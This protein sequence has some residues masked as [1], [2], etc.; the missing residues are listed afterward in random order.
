MTRIPHTDSDGGSGI[1]LRIDTKSVESSPLSSGCVTPTPG[2]L[3]KTFSSGNL[4]TLKEDV[5]L[6]QSMPLP[7]RPSPNKGKSQLAQAID[8]TFAAG[9]EQSTSSSPILSLSEQDT[10]PTN[11]IPTTPSLASPVKSSSNLNPKSSPTKSPSLFERSRIDNGGLN[12]SRSVL[13]KS[14]TSPKK[15]ITNAAAQKP[16]K[17]VRFE[18]YTCF[19]DMLRQQDITGVKRLLESCVIGASSGDDPTVANT[20]IQQQSWFKFSRP[21]QACKMSLFKP[22]LLN[23]NYQNH[24]GVSPLHICAESGNMELLDFIL[25][26]APRSKVTV[27]S[28]IPGA[29]LE[30][31]EEYDVAT[32]NGIYL[33][34][35]DIEGWTPLHSASAEGHIDVV[36]RLVSL[37]ANLHAYNYDGENVYDVAEEE[38]MKAAI[39]GND[40]TSMKYFIY[41]TNCSRTIKT[42]RT[43]K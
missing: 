6:V 8:S 23:L 24:M 7:P 22:K 41:F 21:A 30:A 40:H 14:S 31:S 1:G 25:E 42:P 15:A 43:K 18:T 37:G 2:T 13:V 26:S 12:R 36:K 10:T 34:L 28:P 16:R 5:S 38:D 27:K 9:V 19:F 3:L 33:E 35:L 32:Y 29:S 17:R 4:K 11:S 20:H 39:E